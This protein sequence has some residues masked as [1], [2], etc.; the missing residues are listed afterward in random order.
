MKYKVQRTLASVLAGI[1]LTTSVPLQ[2]F[3]DVNAGGSGSA[4]IAGAFGF[5]LI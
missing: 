3:A 1:M 5:D 4:G 2:S